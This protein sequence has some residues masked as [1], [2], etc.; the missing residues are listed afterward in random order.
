M[1]KSIASLELT[2]LTQ[3]LQFLVDGK[4]SQIYQVEEEFFF[5]L[6]K[7]E[8]KI[9]RIIPGKIINLASEKKSALRPSGFCL[10]LRKYLNN[11]FIKNIKQKDSERILILELQKEEK[12]NLIIELF[13]PGNLILTNKDNII[14][15]AVHQQRFKDRFIRPKE[16]YVPPPSTNNW[17]NLTSNQLTEILKQSTRKNLAATLAIEL[18]LGGLYAEEVCILSQIDKNKTS[19]ETLPKEIKQIIETI[20]LLIKK[21]KKPTG[22]IYL[23]QITPFS[24]TNQQPTKTTKTYS[25]ALETIDFN[26]KKSPYEKK[27]I[28]QKKIIEEQE[29]SVKKQKNLIEKNNQKAELIY[30][31]Y[32]PLNKLLEITKELKKTKNWNEIKTTLQKEKK[33]KKI[34]LKNKKLSIDL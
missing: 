26:Q 30:E 10:Q 18:G 3:E 13:A 4:I 23:E 33:I 21:L 34:D 29:K 16:K 19:Q 32:Q 22:N 11:S 27:I 2:A 24:L 25:E 31:K 17:K 20:N 9:V 15:A 6:H 12:F 5:Q 8:K 14:L 7:K 28:S 1:K